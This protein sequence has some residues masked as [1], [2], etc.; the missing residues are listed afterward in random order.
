LP[1]NRFR[2]MWPEMRDGTSALLTTVV[3]TDQG[4]GP[5]EQ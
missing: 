2:L 1:N 5:K 3:A 4:T